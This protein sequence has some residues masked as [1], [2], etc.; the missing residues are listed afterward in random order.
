MSGELLAG[1]GRWLLA[2]AVEPSTWRGLTLLSTA[3]GAATLPGQIDLV[4]TVG[5]ALAGLL[6]AGTA[7][8]RR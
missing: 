1:A 8:K 7:D 3:A 5:L 6:G 4:L 2:R